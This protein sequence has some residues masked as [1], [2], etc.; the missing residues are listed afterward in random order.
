MLQKGS[1]EKFKTDLESLQHVEL[2]EYDMPKV[3]TASSN[4]EFRLESL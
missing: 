2:T 4:G 1:F 3:L